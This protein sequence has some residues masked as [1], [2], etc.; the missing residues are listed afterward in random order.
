M[1]EFVKDTFTGASG[2]DITTRAGETGATWAK[3]TGTS[4]EPAPAIDPSGLRLFSRAGGNS[5]V[6]SSGVATG[7]A[8][9]EIQFDTLTD[10][11]AVGVGIR[12]SATQGYFA[13]M[14]GGIA[15]IL[16]LDAGGGFT[17][18]STPGGGVLKNNAVGSHT[19][20]IKVTGV[21]ATVAIEVKHDGA[22]LLTGADSSAGRITSAGGVGIFTGGGG[23]NDT[24]GHHISSI[25]ADTL[26]AVDS[27]APT[28]SS[29]AVANA[30]PSVIAMTMS[31]TL[32][33]A[34]VPAASAFAVAGHTVSSVAI[35]GAMIN[36]TVTPAFFNGEASRTVS[37]T[38]PASNQA[39]DTA[40][41]ELAS[42]TDLAITN[43]VAATAPS[44]I[45]FATIVP[46]PDMVYQQVAGVV[47]TIAVSGTYSGGA[48]TSIQARIVL[49]GTNTPVTGFDWAT[50]VANPSGGG[51]AFNFTNVPEP[52][53]TWYEIQYRDS[54]AP[55]TIVTAG[56]FG[57]G[58]LHLMFGQSNSRMIL[59]IGDSS[60]SPNPLL[61]MHGDM[62]QWVVPSAATN[63]GGITLGNALIAK[64]N[65]PT[66]ILDF[67]VDGSGLIMLANNTQWAPGTTGS[68]YQTFRNLMADIRVTRIASATWI[69]G[70][71]EG[72]LYDPATVENDYYAGMVALINSV[73]TDY[74]GGANAPFVVVMHGRR[75]DGQAPDAGVEGV[76]RAQKRLADLTGVLLVERFDC[77]L[78]DGLHHTVNGYRRLALLCAQAIN[79]TAGLVSYYRGPSISSTTRV[80]ANTIDLTLTH[81]GGSDFTPATG[82]T[83]L[84][85]LS[86]ATV[87]AMASA[88]RTA[89]NKIRVA[90]TGAPTTALTV[91]H[92]YGA[93][94]IDTALVKDN[95]A[96]AMPLAYS[97]PVTVAAVGGDITAPTLSSPSATQTGSTTATGSVTTNETG[98]TLYRYA[99]I[100]PSESAATVKAANLTQV[101]SAGGAQSVTFTGLSASTQYYPHYLHRD[102]AG[103]DSMVVSGSAFSTAAA[104]DSTAPTLTGQLSISAVTHN[105]ATLSWPTASDNVAVT[106]YERSIDGGVTY[107]AVGSQPTVGLTGLASSTTFQVRVRA[108]D[109]AGNRSAALSGSF[110]TTAAPGS[111]G[112]SN[113]VPSTYRTVTVGV[114]PKSFSAAGDFW[115]MSG[116]KTPRGPKDPDST[117]DITFDWG[118]WL[119]DMGSPAIANVTF[120]LVGVQSAGGSTTGSKATV[121]LSGGA[122]GTEASITCR[123][124]TASTPARIDDRTV[125]LSL[126]E[127]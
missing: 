56:R 118:P 19:L 70:E 108:Y 102:A 75:T 65:V 32:D 98:G 83:G 14:N 29:A 127:Q 43:S 126:G 93:A 73:R 64:R 17:D 121:F 87:V 46:R 55:G 116:A 78:D 112:E 89:A 59:R 104:A 57:V 36:L 58:D 77:E 23:Y 61:R 12:C 94:P 30:S 4:G 101:V 15:R 120:T 80:D 45:T 72:K 74:T 85:V 24:S 79:Y 21:G 90:L 6:Y 99:S 9:A 13:H 63:T 62:G 51:F 1:T 31:E 53:G 52:V 35:A 5:I 7:D 68:T 44:N 91:Q 111:G 106:G 124:T 96:L 69:Q 122:V 28:V 8:I 67:G 34:F 39:R 25:T 125:Y 40:G 76:K 86:G 107:V 97:A 84:R 88:V 123:V 26:A 82:I 22:V 95:S 113:F 20:S 60:V 103:N 33:S 100:N 50:K 37:Y 54:A 115:S 109:A 11:G 110:T 16:R 10:S 38:K 18:V 66:V 41:N 48:P 71:T 2:A 119:A 49:E 114:A 47:A 42:F 117:I 27:T 92:M 105:A 81:S 3:T